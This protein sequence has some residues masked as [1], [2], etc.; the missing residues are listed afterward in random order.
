MIWLKISEEPSRML[1]ARASLRVREIGTLLES[2]VGLRRLIG[3]GAD[4][5]PASDESKARG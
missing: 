4:T 2:I 5:T 1:S 3:L